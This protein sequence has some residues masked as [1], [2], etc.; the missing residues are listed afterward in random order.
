MLGIYNIDPSKINFEI[1]EISP[2]T[3]ENSKTVI[4]NLKLISDM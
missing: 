1:V 3:N 2:I 4:K